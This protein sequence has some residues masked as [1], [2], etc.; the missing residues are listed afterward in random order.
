MNYV[1]NNTDKVIFLAR[2]YICK[3]DNCYHYVRVYVMIPRDN[4][5]LIRIYKKNLRKYYKEYPSPL[6][7]EYYNFPKKFYW[8]LNPIMPAF[9]KINVKDYYGPLLF[10][11]VWF[12]VFGD[13]YVEDVIPIS[14]LHFY[15]DSLHSRDYDKFLKIYSILTSRPSQKP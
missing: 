8:F 15:L 5:E 6:S 4:I 12:G 2:P 14:V 7:C 10:P 13:Y 1:M 11:G 9:R 3:D